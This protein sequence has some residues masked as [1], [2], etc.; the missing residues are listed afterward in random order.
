MTVPGFGCQA[1]PRNRV[2]AAHYGK[3]KGG[4]RCPISSTCLRGPH[5]DPEAW[6]KHCAEMDEAAISW[7]RLRGAAA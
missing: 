2:C 5:R 6:R 7:E 1:I 3:H 4:C